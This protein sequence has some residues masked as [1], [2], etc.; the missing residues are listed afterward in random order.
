MDT[1][2]EHENREEELKVTFYPE[3]YLQRRIWILNFLRKEGVTRVCSLLFFFCTPKV[4]V[5][6]KPRFST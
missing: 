6:L 4:L 3:L 5:N 1:I 2:S